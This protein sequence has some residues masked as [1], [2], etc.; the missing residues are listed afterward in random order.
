[1]ETSQLSAK[2]CKFLPL[3]NTC[4]CTSSSESSLT[5]HTYCDKG[6]SSIMSTSRTHDTHFCCRA[7]CHYLFERL[8]SVA[9]GILIQYFVLTFYHILCEYIHVNDI[10]IYNTVKISKGLRSLLDTSFI[11]CQ[12]TDLDFS[13]TEHFG[14]QTQSYM[15]S[16]NILKHWH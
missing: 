14:W 6:H 15:P 9:T 5:Y 12:K 2:G 1:M 8:I 4:T 11:Y 7:S 10:I 16:P 13:Q 3:L